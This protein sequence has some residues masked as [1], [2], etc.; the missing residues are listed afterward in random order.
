[1]IIV[2]IWIDA[3]TVFFVIYR[4]FSKIVISLSSV[5]YA[6]DEVSKDGQMSQC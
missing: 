1:M 5:E 6:V 3:S 2:F 4:L